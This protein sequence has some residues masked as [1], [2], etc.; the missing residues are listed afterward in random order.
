MKF[1]SRSLRLALA[2]LI[3]AAAACS[4]TQSGAARKVKQQGDRKLAPDFALKDVNGATVRLSD[5]RGK[6]VLLNFWATWCGPCKIEIPWFIE[7]EQKHKDRGFAVLGISMDDGGWEVVRPFLARM[8]VNYRTL[9]GDETV[10]ELYGGVASLPTSFLIDREGRIAS[11]HLGL[12]SKSVYENE[13]EQLLAAPVAQDSAADS[14]VRLAGGGANQ[15][16]AQR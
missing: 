5:Y 13:I 7:F 4:P 8:K 1:T 3:L 14:A 9:M 6:V 11:A 12:V 15:P 16:G 10:A 2:M